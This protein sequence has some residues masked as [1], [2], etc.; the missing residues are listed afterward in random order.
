MNDRKMMKETMNM[1]A[2]IV[3]ILILVFIYKTEGTS[4]WFWILA[5]PGIGI[6]ALSILSMIFGEDP[7]KKEQRAMDNWVDYWAKGGPRQEEGRRPDDRLRLAPVPQEILDRR[8]RE[9]MI[10][11]M[12]AMG[13]D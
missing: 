2:T 10:A 8:H 11:M 4:T 1:L 7:K 3:Y 12:I 6:M 5:W 13:D 9:E